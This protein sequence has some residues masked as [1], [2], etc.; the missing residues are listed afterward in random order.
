MIIN[1]LKNN[2]WTPV[3]SLTPL[4]HETLS[5][6]TSGLYI[7]HFH[8]NDQIFQQISSGGRQYEINPGDHIY[9]FGKFTGNILQRITGNLIGYNKYWRYRPAENPHAL[10]RSYVSD[11]FEKSTTRYLIFDA[12]GLS[13][14]VLAKL[15][16]FMST[17]CFLP[18]RRKNVL[19]PCR[20]FYEFSPDIDAE[21]FLKLA[22]EAQD[23][24]N[25]FIKQQGDDRWSGGSDV[26]NL[27]PSLPSKLWFKLTIKRNYRDSF[28]HPNSKETKVVI[29]DSPDNNLRYEKSE[30]LSGTLKTSIIPVDGENLRKI[31]NIISIFNK[32]PLEAIQKIND[33][34]LTTHIADYKGLE[35]EFEAFKD[36]RL[37]KRFQL[38]Y[39]SGGVLQVKDGFLKLISEI[40]F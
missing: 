32:D 17:H 22:I 31:K 16:K 23:K 13:N 24:I 8:P 18:G 38:S 14:H 30:N 4:G 20:E 29:V 15:E 27:D 37:T 6:I 28:S 21:T 11:A 19:K 25:D 1:I 39:W 3:D 9:K 7:F 36:A 26:Y 33:S 34:N 2:H 12:T 35:I 10:N 5:N 40:I